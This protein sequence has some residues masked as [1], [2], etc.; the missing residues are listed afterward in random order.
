MQITQQP[1]VDKSAK[2]KENVRERASSLGRIL[3]SLR[4]RSPF[5]RTSK[6]NL[7]YRLI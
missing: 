4:P 2:K 1:I 6:P 7:E 5:T 3:R